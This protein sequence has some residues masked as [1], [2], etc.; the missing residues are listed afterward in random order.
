MLM[1]P[2]FMTLTNMDF[3]PKEKSLKKLPTNFIWIDHQMLTEKKM[4]LF[5]NY[6]YYIFNYLI[7]ISF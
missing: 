5:K 7:V 3:N 6:Y 4:F 2:F 1:S